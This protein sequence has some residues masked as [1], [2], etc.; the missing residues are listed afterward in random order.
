MERIK[1]AL[2]MARNQR[3]AG[4]DAQIEAKTQRKAAPRVSGERIQYTQTRSFVPDERVL[5]ENRILT[6]GEENQPTR[7]IKMLRTQV[8]QRMLANNWNALAITS[9]GPGQGKTLT[10]V[11]LAISLARE[12]SY[13]VLLVDLDLHHPAVHRFFGH[14]P[15]VGLDDYLEGAAEVPDIL[16]HPSIE[17]LVVLPVRRGMPNSSELLSSPPMHALV[18]ELKSRYP[19]RFVLFDLPPLL[20]V[21]DALAFAPYVDAVLLV[22]EEGVTTKDDIVHSMELLKNT[23][24]LGTVLNKSQAQLTEAY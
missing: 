19:S 11:N 3:E 16:L 21:D 1:K 15:I 17:H 6:G 4:A 22:I 10:A 23:P 9:P 20:S 5:R 7:A 13:S 24:V 8:L 14:Q 18:D 2:E 12:V